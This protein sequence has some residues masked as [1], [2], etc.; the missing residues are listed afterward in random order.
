M[1]LKVFSSQTS[2]ALEFQGFHDT[3]KFIALVAKYV[4][5]FNSKS[6]KKGTYLRNDM[7]KPITNVNCE[8]ISFLESFSDMISNML[9]VEGRRKPGDNCLTR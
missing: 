3:A 7:M 5:V 6:P 9:P 8:Q 2:A 4:T 1:A